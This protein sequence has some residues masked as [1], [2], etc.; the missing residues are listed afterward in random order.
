MKN[1]FYKICSSIEPDK[2]IFM[3]KYGDNKICIY[4]GNEELH[5]TIE[6]V[7]EIIDSLK[8]CILE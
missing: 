5:F 4:V 2:K 7:K 6:E 8:K 3:H 1:K